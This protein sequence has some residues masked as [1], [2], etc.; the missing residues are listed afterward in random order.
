MTSEVRLPA[1]ALVILVGPSGSGKTTWAGEGFRPDQVVSSDRLRELV[2]A[3]ENDQRAG[4]DAFDVLDLVL[5][6]RLRRG[7]LTV[8]DSLGLDRSRRRRWLEAAARHGRPGHVVVFDIGERE[9]RRR[10]RGRDRPVPPKV[11]SGQLRRFGDARDELAD[12]G[13]DHI[14]E[15]G[16][17]TVVA[18]AFTFSPEWAR[19]QQEAPVTLRF[20]LHIPTFDWPGDSAAVAG[21]LG[22]VA[23]QAEG[24]GFTSLWVMDHM[25]QIPQFGRAWD[26]ILESYTTLGYLA[27]RTSTMRL[28]TMVTGI[29]YRNLGHLGKVLAT[30]DVLSGGRAMCGLGAAWYEREHRAYGWRFPPLGERYKLLEDAL[31]FLPLMWGPGSPPF[32]G[33]RFSAAEAVCYPRPLQDHL[34]ILVGGSGERRTLRL[35]ARYADACN[36]FGEPAVVRHKVEV[37]HQHCRDFDRDPA[38]VMVTQLSTILCA[39]DRAAL[40]ERIDA[41]RGDEQPERWAARTNAGTVEDHVGRFRAMAEAGVQEAMVSL[42]DIGLPGAVER[43]APVIETFRAR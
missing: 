40:A 42:R 3:G 17:A 7:L 19:R 21:H 4:T 11:L 29:T 22:E 34:P 15:V 24:V 43:F 10:N 9:C 41:L 6:R 30:L 31:Q 32:P 36:L 23:A 2:G 38:E 16:P 39:P 13:A 35:A 12:D 26:P 33:R 14:H 8:V 37:L 28:G 18:P 25:V 1:D 5:E 27:G 20:G